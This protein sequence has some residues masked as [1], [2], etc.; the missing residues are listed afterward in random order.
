MHMQKWPSKAL[1][2]SQTTTKT[3]LTFIMFALSSRARMAG[4]MSWMA[5]GEVRLTEG[6]SLGPERMYLLL[7]DQMSF[8]GTWSVSEET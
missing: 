6:W 8:A 5:I 3:R 2:E 7:V 4:Y 1:Q